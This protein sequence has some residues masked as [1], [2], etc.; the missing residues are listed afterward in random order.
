MPKGIFEEIK[1]NNNKVKKNYY[2]KLID[3]RIELIKLLCVDKQFIELL[4]THST[5]IEIERQQLISKGIEPI[6]GNEIER[7][8][9]LVKD[10]LYELGGK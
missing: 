7:F 5:I 4:E 9:I 1:N 3:D 8:K 10:A 2:E 6:R